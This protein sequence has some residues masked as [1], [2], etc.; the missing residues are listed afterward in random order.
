[1]SSRRA[2]R[3]GE[4]MKQEISDLIQRGIKDPHLGFVTVIEVELTNDLRYARVFVSV[5]GED[6]DDSPT[7]KSLRKASGFIRSQ[8]ARRIRLRHF[9]EIEFLWD[10][11]IEQGARISKLLEEITDEGKNI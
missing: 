6:K 3:V 11:S 1:M 9:P 7:L 2:K 10:S 4:L 8:L 5:Y